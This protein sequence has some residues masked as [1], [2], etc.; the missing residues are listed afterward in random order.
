[1]AS[2][3]ETERT[4]MREQLIKEFGE[5]H[6]RMIIMALDW[7]DEAE[8]GWGLDRPLSRRGYIRDLTKRASYKGSDLLDQRLLTE[9]EMKLFKKRE[10]WW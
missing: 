2:G 6:R 10:G 5:E 1:M 3:K 4:I 9:E 7:L 8:P